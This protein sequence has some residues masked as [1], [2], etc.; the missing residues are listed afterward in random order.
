LL[1]FFL[2]KIRTFDFLFPKPPYFS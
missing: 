2:T 1:E